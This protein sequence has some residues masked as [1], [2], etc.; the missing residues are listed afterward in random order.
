[1]PNSPSAIKRLRQSKK[2]RAR[3]RVAK[4]VIKTFSK[5]AMEQAASGNFEQAETDY[6]FACSKLDK[7]CVRRVLHPNTAAR[8]KS[9]MALEFAE[10]VAKGKAKANPA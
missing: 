8:R 6:R 9:R 4:K 5:R 2:R 7:A 10:A 1:M 3:N